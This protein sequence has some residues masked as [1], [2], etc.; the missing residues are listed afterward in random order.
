MLRI[1][2]VKKQK[3][4]PP[5]SRQPEVPYRTIIPVLEPVVIVNGTSTRYSVFRIKLNPNR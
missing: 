2:E 4:T 1:K 3:K 5:Q